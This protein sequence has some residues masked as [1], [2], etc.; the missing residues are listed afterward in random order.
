MQKPTFSIGQQVAINLTTT[1]YIGVIKE[2]RIING[3]WKYGVSISQ[4]NDNLAWVQ[5]T[6]IIYVFKDGEWQAV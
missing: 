2:G 3:G 6:Q 4:K 5:V 1:Q